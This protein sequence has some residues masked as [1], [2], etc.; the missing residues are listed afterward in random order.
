MLR[1]LVGSH[2]PLER[3]GDV[4][5]FVAAAA[6][7][8][9]IASTNGVTNL[10]AWGIIPSGLYRQAWLTWWLGDLAGL[11]ILA[12]VIFTL[13]QKSEF[14]WTR[15]RKLEAAA[16]F[17][18]LAAATQ[19]LFG[20][21]SAVRDLEL[22]DSLAYAVVPGLAWAAFRFGPRET[23]LA[24]ALVSAVAIVNTS[25]ESGPF[26]P[27][28]PRIISPLQN[29]GW[30][31]RQ[32]EIA[33]KGTNESST[34]RD[35]ERI[36]GPPQWVT[37]RD[38]RAMMDS[39]LKQRLRAESLLMLQVFV[40]SIA[41]TAAMLAGA[42]TERNSSEQA[43]REL[44]A[45]LE[46]RVVERTA[47]L[48]QANA[49]LERSNQEL[50]DF[51]YIASHDLKEP[52]RGINTYSGYL[53]EDYGDKLDAD[54]QSKLNTLQRLT[55]RM[56][57]LIESLL[58]YSRVG[59]TEL[60]VQ[61]TNLSEVL[62]EILDSLVVVLQECGVEIRIP[63][64]LP[65]LYCDRVRV[66]EVFRNLITNAMKYNESP[67]KWIEIGF[68]NGSAGGA[69]SGGN[70]VPTKEFPTIFHVRDNGIGIREKHL[71]SVFKMFKRL[72]ARDQYGGGTGVGLTIVK[73]IVERHG[74]RI[75]LESTFGEGTTFFFTL[76]QGPS[77]ATSS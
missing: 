55:R 44:N 2:N 77:D 10:W 36:V 26:Y 56:E 25:N 40:L 23:A 70:G 54:G 74:G 49:A 3:A 41:I 7:G 71:N 48:N 62:T 9:L 68:R 57:S 39:D 34:L 29:V 72:N 5:R 69:D 13:F 42:V 43:L 27:R 17:A 45:T 63:Q 33:Q 16:L 67:E 66:G 15:S 46:Q 28:P 59:R 73:K 60:A 22:M 65:T 50:D 12:P 19:F 58:T 6:I 75:W 52:L 20:D 4:F 1:R 30:T 51:A 35:L 18:L 64:P 11:L 76:Q 47:E 31:P 37:P 21:Y 61:D 8:C 38:M 32:S 24:A 14:G 53:L